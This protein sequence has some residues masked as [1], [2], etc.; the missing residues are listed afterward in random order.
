MASGSVLEFL[1]FTCVE[2][3][4][5]GLTLFSNPKAGSHCSFS[6]KELCPPH[7]KETRLTE[8]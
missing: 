4:R 1:S 8:M 3:P 6:A 7:Q 2:V 5:I